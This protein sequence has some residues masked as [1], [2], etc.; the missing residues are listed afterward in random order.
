MTSEYLDLP[1]R[2]LRQVREEAEAEHN[3]LS[4]TELM[5][6]VALWT[7]SDMN[8]ELMQPRYDECRQRLDALADRLETLDDEIEAQSSRRGSL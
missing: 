2:S 5:L 7:A 6:T 4:Q 8:R 1:L 3:K